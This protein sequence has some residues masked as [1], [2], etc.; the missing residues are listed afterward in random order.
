MDWLPRRE[1]EDRGQ[2][3]GGGGRN[4]QDREPTMEDARLTAHLLCVGGEDHHLRIPF[5]LALRRYGFR[6]SAAS[7]GDPRLFARAGLEHRSFYFDRFVNPAADWAAVKRLAKLFADLRPD[8]VQSFDTK[9]SL[10]VPLA[11]RGIERVRVVRTINGMGWLYSSQAPIA[12]ILRVAYRLLHQHAACSVAATVF[13]NCADQ[14]YFQRHAM[15]DRVTSRLIPGSGVDIDAFYQALALAPSPPQLRQTLG[16]GNAEVVIT[17][18]RLSR[19]KGI[20]TLLEAAALVHRERPSVRFLLVGPRESEGPF[21]ISQTETDRHAPYVLA[22]GCRHDIPALLSIADVFAFPTEYREGVPRVLLEAAL[23]GIP[24][25]TTSMPGCSDVVHDGWTGLVIPPGSP[26]ALA[27]HILKL[28]DD[29]QKAREMARRATDVAR[30]D[31]GLE[32]TAARYA[33]VYRDILEE[34]VPGIR[35]LAQIGSSIRCAA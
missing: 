28:L 25:V 13:Q 15:A 30:W 17:V 21:A 8:I 34:V 18:T 3:R 5:M 35:S 14:D 16:L 2:G 10:L 1:R 9:P 6:V 33:A 22:L 19:Q 24:I 20:A 12:L 11:A 32:L 7:T 26:M 23:A 29:P 4:G 31:F 27:S